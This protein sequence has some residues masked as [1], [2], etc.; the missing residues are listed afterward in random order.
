LEVNENKTPFQQ[1]DFLSPSTEEYSKLITG[2]INYSDGLKFNNSRSGVFKLIN[3][4]GSETEF[5]FIFNEVDNTISLT[6]IGRDDLIT[7]SKKITNENIE[8]IAKIYWDTFTRLTKIGLKFPPKDCEADPNKIIS[9]QVKKFYDLNKTRIEKL[10]SKFS[11]KI[12]QALVSLSEYESCGSPS[13]STLPKA[14]SDLLS[15]IANLKV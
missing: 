7:V 13:S 15:R 2:M 10:D 4:D 12:V 6:P 1:I 11:C 5:S 8:E 3:K 14:K 9:G